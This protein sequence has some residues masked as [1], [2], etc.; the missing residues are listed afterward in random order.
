MIV[1]ENLYEF[2]RGMDPKRALG[3]SRIDKIIDW[4]EKNSPNARY[5]IGDNFK[6]TIFG[7]I[8]IEEGESWIPSDMIIDGDFIA[9]IKDNNIKKIPDNIKV[10]GSID[11]LSSHSLE[12]IG[13]NF[14]SKDY[15]GFSMTSLKKIGKNCHIGGNLFLNQ[16]PISYL[17]N[18]IRVEGNLHIY[19]TNIIKIPQSAEIEGEIIR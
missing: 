14:Y 11:F 13:D 18:D 3:I 15:A 19:K 1:R 5:Q 8:Y 12:E 6:V 10:Y 16:S 4:L 17:P 2:E 7:N 9:H